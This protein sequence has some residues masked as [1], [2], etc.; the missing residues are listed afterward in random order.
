ME[1]RLENDDKKFYFFTAMVLNC[2]HIL[3]PEIY[4]DILESLSIMSKRT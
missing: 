4:I 2:K 1:R 3:K